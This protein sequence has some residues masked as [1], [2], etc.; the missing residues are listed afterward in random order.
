MRLRGDSAVSSN[1]R[2]QGQSV[3]IW[4]RMRT[5]VRFHVRELNRRPQKTAER[6]RE[7][8]KDGD[9]R[10][11]IAEQ[12]SSELIAAVIGRV[13]SPQHQG[14][15]EPEHAHDQPAASGGHP[16]LSMG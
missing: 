3:T 6:D 16:V 1:P 11:I 4:F 8:P 2:P 14:H 10:R 7:E 13:A 15:A 5:P 12:C 9:Q